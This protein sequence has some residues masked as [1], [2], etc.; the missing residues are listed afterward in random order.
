[1]YQPYPYQVP[2]LH[3]IDL[4]RKSGKRSALVVLASGLG[5]TVVAG[6]D[7]R[8]FMSSHPGAKVLYL[9]HQN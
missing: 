5:K 9:C 1:M 4:A 2:V 3:A 8:R 6:F 7:I